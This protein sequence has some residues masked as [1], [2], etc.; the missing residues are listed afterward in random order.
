[1]FQDVATLPMARGAEDTI[2]KT[3]RFSRQEERDQTGRS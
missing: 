2:L 3:L 1:M